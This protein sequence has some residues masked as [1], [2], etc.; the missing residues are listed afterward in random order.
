M[1]NF[2]KHIKTIIYFRRYFTFKKLNNYLRLRFLNLLSTNHAIFSK[3]V[4]PVFISIEPNNFCQLHCPECPVGI[5]TEIRSN[6]IDEDVCIRAIDELKEKLFHVIFYFQGEPLLNKNLPKLIEY[7]H[8]ARIFTSTSTNAQAL[9]FQLAKEIVASGLDK[10]IISI[11]GATQEVYEKYRIGGKLQK[12][13]EGVE[14]INHWK[15]QLNS[16][17]PLVEIQFIVFKTNEHQ[18][19]EMKQIKKELNADR[20]VFKTAQLYDFENGNELLTTIDK[21]SRYKKSS[22]GK[23]EIKSPLKNNC[24]RMWLG[25]V[26]NSEGKV[27]PCCFDKNAE[28]S[29]GNLTESSFQTIWHND[30]ANGFRNSI[31]QN[32]KQHEMCRNCSER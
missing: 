4:L 11:D 16:L 15:K 13:K 20:L 25:S 19:N 21:Y 18:L 6:R 10:I 26:I 32:R 1:Q 30:K 28:Y 23:Y 24:N 9:T 3:N 7:A 2:I 17:T 29:Y 31:L 8:N 27:L 5:R 22:T 12:V 14:F